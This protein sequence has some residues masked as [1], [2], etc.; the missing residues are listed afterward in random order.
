MTQVEPAGAPA[1]RRDRAS[2]VGQPL[3][4]GVAYNLSMKI[5][6]PIVAGS[7]LA[8]LLLGC[9]LVPGTSPTYRVTHVAGLGPF[10]QA[11]LDWQPGGSALGGLAAAGSSNSRISLLFPQSEVCERLLAV[12][13]EPEY[14]P[15]GMTGTIRVGEETCEAVGIASP[16]EWRDR[17]PRPSTHQVLPRAQATYRVVHRDADIAVLRGRFP[18][19]SHIGWVGSSDT[20]ALMPTSGKCASLLSQTVA[21]MEYRP[22]GRIATALISK[23]GLCGLV[24][25][26]RPSDRG[27]TTYGEDPM[28]VGA[29]ETRPEQSP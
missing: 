5:L 19:A 12:G 13:S 4:P 23:Q 17:R 2:Q 21:S 20:L 29:S 16:T 18:L 14:L 11:Q 8:T 7:M 27:K 9:P 15:R 24:G 10:T 6:S 22:V 3:P 26:A 25:F 1:T 28:E